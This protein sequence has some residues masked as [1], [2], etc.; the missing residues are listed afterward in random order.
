MYAEPIL[1]AQIVPAREKTVHHDKNSAN[2]VYIT[3]TTIKIFPNAPNL[4]FGI[5][6]FWRRKRE[7]IIQYTTI[8]RIGVPT[9]TPSRI[10]K[11]TAGL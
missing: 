8:N 11:V 7:R 10:K 3:H 2:S 4:S 1:P 9:S 6:R 5:K